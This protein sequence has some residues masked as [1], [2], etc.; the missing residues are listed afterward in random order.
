LRNR[1]TKEGFRP[2]RAGRKTMLPLIRGGVRILAITLAAAFTVAAPS[3]AQRGG[4]GATPTMPEVRPDPPDETDYKA[5]IGAQDLEKKIKLGRQFLQNYPKNQNDGTVYRFLVASYFSKEDWVDFYATADEAIA[6][7][8]DD[9]EILTVVGWVIP[10]FYDEDEAD[11]RK[12]LDKAESYEKRAME[13]IETVPKPANL[14]DEQFATLKAERLSRAHSGL[15]LVYYRTQDYENSV[16]ELQ[17]ATQSTTS[18]DQTDLYALAFGLEQLNRFVEALD[19]FERCGLMPGRLQIRC[20]VSV[21]TA[22]SRA[23]ES[24]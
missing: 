19:A 8:P 7:D 3:F 10:H 14:T 22:K 16:K 6:K 1:R 13:L 17:Q 18:P 5:F 24:K 9:V 2:S 23:L 4:R 20:Q 15:G 11:A 12:K 21:D